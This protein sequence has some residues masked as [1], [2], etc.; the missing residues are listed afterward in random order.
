M[1]RSAAEKGLWLVLCLSVGVCEEVIYRGY[2]LSRL[3]RAFRNPA[4]ALLVQAV[5]YGLLHFAFGATWIA[6]TTA[7]GLFFGLIVLWRRSLWPAVIVHVLVDA[8]AVFHGQ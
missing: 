6:F 5:C 4:V 3:A 1:P 8:L 2:C 7:A